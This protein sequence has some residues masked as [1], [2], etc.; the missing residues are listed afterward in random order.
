M[1]VVPTE[2]CWRNRTREGHAMD[3]PDFPCFRYIRYFPLLV[4]SREKAGKHLDGVLHSPII[5]S[6]TSPSTHFVLGDLVG[7]RA[8]LLMTKWT[9]SDRFS[10]AGG[11][12]STRHV[13]KKGQEL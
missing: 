7:L 13:K 9:L 5:Y 4:I 10:E 12:S 1:S 8:K 3:V 2:F 11:C 6:V